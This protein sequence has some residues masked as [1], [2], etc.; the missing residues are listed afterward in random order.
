MSIDLSLIPS[1]D[2]AD[3]L[4]RR[5]SSGIIIFTTIEEDEVY[6]NWIGGYYQALGLCAEMQNLIK[7]DQDKE[8]D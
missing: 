4:I 6:Y 2:L 8:K 5:A 3:E 1:K 7:E